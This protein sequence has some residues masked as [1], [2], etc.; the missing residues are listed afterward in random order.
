MQAP[1]SSEGRCIPR[2]QL[3]RISMQ[4]ERFLVWRLIRCD[5][6]GRSATL[7]DAR[8]ENVSRSF[9]AHRE[10]QQST[11]FGPPRN[12]SFSRFKEG[13][14][15]MRLPSVMVGECAPNAATSLRLTT[16]GSRRTMVGKLQIDDGMAVVSGEVVATIGMISQ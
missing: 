1:P 5:A 2:F 12:K 13:P 4:T 16:M 7:Q 11:R 8:V 15:L 6:L 3:Y 10:P 9:H 14:F